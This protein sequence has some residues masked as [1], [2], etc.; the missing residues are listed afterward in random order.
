MEGGDTWAYDSQTAVHEMFNIN[1]TEDGSGDMGTVNGQAGTFTEGMSFIYSGENNWMDRLAPTGSA[2]TILEN[3][4][5][6]YATAIAYD[7]GSYRTIGASHEFGG[8]NDGGS[9][10]TKVELM[11]EYLEFFAINSSLTAMF[12]SDMTSV[13]QGSSVSFTDMSA[14]DVVSWAWEFEG[15]T[16]A[17]SNDEN[18]V[19]TYNTMG[20][21]DVTLTVSDG[22]DE[23]EM[24]MEDYISVI[25]EPD[26]PATPAGDEMVCIFTS[27]SDYTISEVANAESYEWIL[28]PSSMGTVSGT[29]TTVSVDWNGEAGEAELKV[30]AENDCGTSAYSSVL[31]IEI[32]S[33]DASLTL[34]YDTVC[35]D[36][37]AVMLEGGSPEGGSYSGTG[38]FFEDDEYWL[39]PEVAGMGEH[40]ITYTYT[41]EYGCGPFTA[42]DMLVV[43][44]CEGIDTYFNNVAMSI[45]PNP[46]TGNFNLSV[47]VRTDEI[48]EIV[49]IN[50]MNEI[51]YTENNIAANQLNNKE[52]DLGDVSGGVYF[53]RIFNNDLNVIKKVVINK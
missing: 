37:G 44:L 13:C 30:A 11:T 46:N 14:G 39:D 38:V 20:T 10:S 27:S 42:T 34:N 29:G 52:I 2:F 48:V 5:P 25:G 28:T 31:S 45:Y 18:P 8:L 35:Y 21:F 50:A 33:I 7:E 17:T 43:D 15:G 26:A 12:T 49:I 9:P 40:E 47:N 36:A 6:N 4:S 1:G 41:D 19:V 22:T 3:Q 16:P 51:V 53:V 32:Y 23:S 24:Y